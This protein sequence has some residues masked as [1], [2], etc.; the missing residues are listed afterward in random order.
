[1]HRRHMPFDVRENMPAVPHGD[2][3]RRAGLPLCR[4]IDRSLC[5]ALPVQMRQLLEPREQSA[6]RALPDG[7]PVAAL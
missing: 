4:G 3:L 7:D 2:Q 6:I 5:I 1:M